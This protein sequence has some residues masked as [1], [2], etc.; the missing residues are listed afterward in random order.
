MS[1][2]MTIKTSIYKIESSVGL[3]VYVELG[4]R[5]AQTGVSR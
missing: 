2:I 5:R 3:R 4:P 1:I